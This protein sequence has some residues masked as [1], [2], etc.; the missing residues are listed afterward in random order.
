MRRHINGSQMLSFRKD[1]SRTEMSLLLQG[2][3]CAGIWL[4]LVTMWIYITVFCL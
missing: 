4:S 3:A 2:A 1:N